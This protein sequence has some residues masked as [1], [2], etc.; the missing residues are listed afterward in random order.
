VADL[1]AIAMG[2]SGFERDSKYTR[3]RA[4]SRSVSARPTTWT[5]APCRG[6]ACRSPGR[7]A[8]PPPCHGPA[9]S[10]VMAALVAAIHDFVRHRTSWMAA[11]R[12]PW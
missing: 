1:A 11:L 10:G 12:R 3:E 9:P 7:R 8:A 2:V 6:R 4:D 5:R